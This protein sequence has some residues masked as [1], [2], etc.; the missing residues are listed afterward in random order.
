MSEQD[1][2]PDITHRG[3]VTKTRLPEEYGITGQTAWRLEKEDPDFPRRVQLTDGGRSGYWRHELDLYFMGRP[4][5][6]AHRRRVQ[7]E[8]AKR[9]AAGAE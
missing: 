5:T 7:K 6:K 2:Y 9:E 1:S 8:A 4:R 3:I